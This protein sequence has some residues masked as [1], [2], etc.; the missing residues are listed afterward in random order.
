MRAFGSGGLVFLA[1]IG[2]LIG[3]AIPWPDGDAPILAQE[4][5][6]LEDLQRLGNWLDDQRSPYGQRL[7][8]EVLWL[9]EHDRRLVTE[10]A[11]L[12]TYFDGLD[13][14]LDRP[15]CRQAIDEH[16]SLGKRQ[17][18]LGWLET[19]VRVLCG[20]ALVEA[21]RGDLEE[22]MRRIEQSRAVVLLLDDDSGEP[23]KTLDL[24]ADEALRAIAREKTLDAR[25]R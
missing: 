18:D 13:E 22:A 20:R 16:R 12:Q 2:V 14:V 24:V 3:L 4:A 17:P 19:Q 5:D 7:A 23:R 1:L 25:S 11:L 6:V 10:M 15:A 21:R 8:G 9:P